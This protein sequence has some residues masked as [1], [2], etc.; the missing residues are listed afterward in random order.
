M[1]AIPKTEWNK[2]GDLYKSGKPM[3]EVAEKYGVSIDAVTYV[4]RKSTIPRRS[5]IEANR[6][7]FEKKTASFTLKLKRDKELETIGAM[8]YWA[9]GYK[10]DKAKGVDFANSNPFMVELF[11]KFLRDR[12]KLDEKRFRAFIY[13]YA[14]QDQLALI[15]FWSKLLAIPFAQFTKPYV[16]KDYRED[17]RKME[18]GMVHLRYGD[19]KMLRDILNLIESYKS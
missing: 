15:K 3:R 9:E 19:K 5:F 6:L 12:Y 7:V 10:T 11:I 16:R 13:C 18:H 14:N 1:P 8:L 4:L 2:V 17:G